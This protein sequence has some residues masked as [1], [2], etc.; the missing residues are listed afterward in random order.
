MKKSKIIVGVIIA[1]LVI[2]VIVESI[3]L[4]VGYYSR[5]PKLKNGEEEVVS[6]STGTKY[7]V[8]DLYKK[9]KSQYGLTALLDLIDAEILDKEFGKDESIES[10]VET[11]IA[12]VKANYPDENKLN[13]FLS[14]YGCSDLDE[15]REYLKTD[16]LKDL[17]SQAYAETLVTEKE[18]KEYYKNDYVG[19]I[20]AKHILV[21]PKDDDKEAA[22][23]LSKK[24]L[25]KINELVK[26]GKS[27][28]EAFEAAYNEYKD[29]GDVT[30]QDLKYF[31]KGDMVEAFET[32]AYKLKVGSY[33]SEPVSTEYGY[34]LIY[35]YDQKEK[36]SLEDAKAEITTTLAKKKVEEDTTMEAKALKELREKYEV[37][38]Y[39]SELQEKYQRYINYMINQ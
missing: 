17:A 9:V 14:Y 32:A 26:S 30:F 31:N 12:T 11:K 3:L 36:A 16:Y 5:V 22:E 8:D 39:D 18:I 37:K 6:L 4:G 33:S 34:H 7:S 29:K 20:A 13:Q 19:D 28:D 2:T 21:A 1:V 25:A 24:I 38:F 35:V 15:Y 10:Y 27:V 23:E